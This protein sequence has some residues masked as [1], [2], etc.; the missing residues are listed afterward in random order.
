MSIVF[1]IL[2][3]GIVVLIHE[4]GHFLIARLFGVRV[5]K[6]SIGFGPSLIA[7]RIGDTVYAISAVPLGGYV[8]MAGEHVG[9]EGATG[10]PDE[11]LSQHWAKRVAIVVAGPLANLVLAVVA[12]CLVGIIGYQVSTPPNLI[13]QVASSAQV[14]GFLPGDRVTAVAGRPIETWHGFMV[15]LDEARPGEAIAVTVERPAGAATLTI[16]AGEAAAIGA[17]LTPR[18]ESV[19]GNVA[20]GMP[21]DQAGLKAGDRVVQVDG[22]PVSTWEEMRKIINARPDA[23]VRLEFER[24]GRRLT[25]TARTLAQ[26]DPE[27]GQRIGV[28]GITLPAVTVTMPPGEALRTGFLQT[29]DMV[30][31]TYSG[32][33]ELVR[34]PQEAVRQVAGPITIAQIAGD[35]VVG[36]PGT[37]LIR[38]AFISVAL[39]A[40][41]LLPIPILDGGHAFLFLIE[42]LRGRR[43]SERA[44]LAFQKVGLVV[45]GSLIVFSLVNDSLRL[46]ERVRAR[47]DLN[48]QV[49]ASQSP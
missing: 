37:L 18:A 34:A 16:P 19:V 5:E 1:G 43:V 25:T 36:A 2:V 26:K 32:F 44:Q 22:V 46:V 42:G 41:N 4:F 21:A 38:V 29:W 23:E 39:M 31:A 15:A 20:P 48:Q 8:K 24:S 9:E 11:F 3:L 27:T 45:I 10:A 6:F 47:H 28:I 49:P 35:S 33:A 17:A 13:D 7:R 14:A 30:R 12:N 40:L